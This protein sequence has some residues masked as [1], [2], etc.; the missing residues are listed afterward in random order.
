M[1]QKYDSR[2]LY[3]PHIDAIE[4]ILLFH[5]TAIKSKRAK[6]EV[7]GND[8]KYF[9]SESNRNDRNSNRNEWETINLSPVC[10]QMRNDE[11]SN[12]FAFV[13]Y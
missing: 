2:D 7:I 13:L 4:F 1:I 5:F 3:R 8:C 11:A 9:S 6:N 10:L 12:V